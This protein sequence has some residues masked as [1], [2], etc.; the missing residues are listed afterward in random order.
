MPNWLSRV[1]WSAALGLGMGCSTTAT[2]LLVAG[3]VLAQAALVGSFRI[4]GQDGPCEDACVETFS[5]AMIACGNLTV[6]QQPACMYQA[7]IDLV[8]CL[9]NCTNNVS[10]P[11]TVHAC[12]SA[13]LASR[14]RPSNRIRTQ[15]A[16]A[17]L[18]GCESR[19]CALVASPHIKT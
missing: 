16:L 12:A 19:I 17:H 18:C 4:R 11:E 14:S 6:N 1:W 10:P 8:A 7:A 13:I 9:G 2:A 15:F 5:A 3:I